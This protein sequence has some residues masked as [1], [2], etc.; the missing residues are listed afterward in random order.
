M[1]DFS[2]DMYACFLQALGKT[3]YKAVTVYE[4]LTGLRPDFFIILRHDVDRFPERALTLAR[5]EAEY[6]ISSTWYFRYKPGVF[7]KDIVKNIFSL[8]HEIGYHYEVLSDSGGNFTKAGKL[9]AS[10]I[11]SMRSIIPVHT[12]A[13][14]G[15]P[16][17]RYSEIRFWDKFT[18][19]DFDL[20]GEAYLSFLQEK[21]PYLNDTGRTWHKNKH[22]LRDTLNQTFVDEDK[23]L[24]VVEQINTSMQLIQFL[25]TKTIPGL[26]LSF[27]PERWPRGNVAWLGS[28][29]FDFAANTLKSLMG[30]YYAA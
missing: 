18:L 21:I 13:M 19:A 29:F 6:N 30:Y 25:S 28:Y 24:A 8:G 1:R 23:H 3:G 17:S 9:F 2:T 27:H 7:K 26:Y 12:C 4:Y 22:N 16:L 14:H 15:R 10:N 5:L 11:T 20:K